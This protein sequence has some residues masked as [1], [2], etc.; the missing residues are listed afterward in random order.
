MVARNL[1][2]STK[3]VSCL[4]RFDKPIAGLANTNGTRE[5][6]GYGVEFA[7]VLDGTDRTNTKDMG[8]EEYAMAVRKRRSKGGVGW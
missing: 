2:S 8:V 4:R 5:V 1:H 3:R 7:I 6:G